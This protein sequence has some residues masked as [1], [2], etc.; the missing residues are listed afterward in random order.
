MAPTTAQ[1]LAT[2]DSVLNSEFPKVHTRAV[3]SMDAAAEFLPE[4]HIIVASPLLM[5]DA[6]LTSA[7]QLQWIQALTAGVDGFTSLQSLRRDVILTSMRGIHG[8]PVSEAAVSA[9]LSLSRDVPAFVRNQDAAEWKRWPVRLLS[10]KTVGI[11]G[12]GVIAETLAPICKA[13]GMHV[14]GFVSEQRAVPGFDEVHLR[15]AIREIVPRLD[16]LVILAPLTDSTRNFV[17]AGVIGAMKP[18]AFLINVARGGIVDEAALVDALRSKRIAG[19]ALDVFSEEPLP[20]AHP[21]WSLE[22]VIVTPHQAGLCDVYPNLALPI[23]RKNLECFLSG[24]T[25]SMLNRI[26][27]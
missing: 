16:Y 10:G 21:F 11:L 1:A 6:V 25:A 5:S 22:N 17:D 23:I 19:A 26:E 27:H 9:M 13:F 3:D 20:R 2:Y 7:P 4:A 18:S 15:D 24:Q 8:P 12:V 14:V